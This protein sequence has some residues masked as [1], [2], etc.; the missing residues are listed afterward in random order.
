MASASSRSV[1]WTTKQIPAL[2]GI[3]LFPLLWSLGAWSSQTT[4]QGD[5]ELAV[6]AGAASQVLIASEPW[7]LITASL[8]NLNLQ[9][10]VTNVAGLIGFGVFAL[11]LFGGV[12]LWNICWLSAW[13][14][15]LVAILSPGIVLGSSAGFFGILGATVITLFWRVPSDRRWLVAIVAIVIAALMLMSP[16]D[17]LAHVGGLITGMCLAKVFRVSPSENAGTKPRDWYITGTILAAQT[18]ACMLTMWNSY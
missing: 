10:L 6:R 3:G 15:T 4:G 17:H 9:H 18:G 12:R 14:G 13:V 2:V 16:G 8:F 7:R 1:Q 11:P 5:V